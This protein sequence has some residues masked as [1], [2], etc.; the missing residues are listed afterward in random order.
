LLKFGV[1][2]EHHAPFDTSKLERL[3][4]I[5]GKKYSG[6]GIS[7]TSVAQNRPI[8]VVQIEGIRYFGFHQ[9]AGEIAATELIAA[10]YPQYGIVLIDEVETSL[11]PRAQRRLVRDLARI[12][13]DRELQI[14]MTT[15]SPYVLEELPPE[16]RIYLMQGVGGKSVVTGVSPD[17]AMTR[18]DE[19]Q[20]PECDVYV[21]DPRAGSMI[22]EILVAA[23]RD[24]LARVKIIP[25]GTSSVG[26]ALWLMAYQKRFPRPSVVF[27]DGDQSEATGCILVPGGDAP[28]RVAFENLHLKEWPDIAQRVGRGPSETIDALNYAMTFSD[29]HEWIRSAADR[30]LLGSDILWQEMCASWVKSCASQ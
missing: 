9:G 25:Y 27:L 19:E 28:E 23:E 21:E 29:H 4:Q 17:F 30:L 6:A 16:A 8:P 10:D 5:V 12:A 26:L 22:S 1:T 3:S 14:V 11:H 15:H 18:M 7:L 2:E 24:L 20:H 13:R